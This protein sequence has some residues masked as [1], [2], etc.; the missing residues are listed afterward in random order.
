MFFFLTVKQRDENDPEG[1]GCHCLV[2]GSSSSMSLHTSGPSAAGA[3]FPRS[4][5]PTL[6]R[7]LLS[8]SAATSSSQATLFSC[9]SVHR[10]LGSVGTRRCWQVGRGAPHRARAW[11]TDPKGQLVLARAKLQPGLGAMNCPL[12]I[13]TLSAAGKSSMCSL[14]L[15]SIHTQPSSTDQ[16]LYLSSYTYLSICCLSW[17]FQSPRSSANSSHLAFAMHLGAWGLKQKHQV[18]VAPNKK[19]EVLEKGF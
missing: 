10:Q 5:F 16:G 7:L 8:F 1:L 2:I 6:A 4:P 9:S 12:C 3:R 11:S 14:S 19:A 18:S 13:P 15:P 17:S